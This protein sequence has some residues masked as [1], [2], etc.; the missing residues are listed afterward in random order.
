M[1]RETDATNKH[2][3]A[4]DFVQSMLKKTLKQEKPKKAKD[5]DTE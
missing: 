2:M 1:S 5:S 4:D 3:V